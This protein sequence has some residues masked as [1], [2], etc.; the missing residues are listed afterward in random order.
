MG[1][2][3]VQGIVAVVDGLP[4][5]QFRQ[6]DDEGNLET[7]WQ[8]TPQEARQMAQQI[9]EASFNAVYDASII[10]WA[11]ET[12]EDEAMGVKLVDI[13]RRYRA[14]IWGLP[15]RPEDW[16]SDKIGESDE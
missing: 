11:R 16:R 10:A 5:V 7:G 9:V 12:T 15:D 3:E 8:A 13:I 2:L 4:Y 14:D 1:R 6:L